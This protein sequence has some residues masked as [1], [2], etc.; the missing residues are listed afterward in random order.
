MEDTAKMIHILEFYRI[1]KDGN[2]NLDRVIKDDV[3]YDN[4]DNMEITS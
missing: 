1:D 3:E 2:W 4:Y